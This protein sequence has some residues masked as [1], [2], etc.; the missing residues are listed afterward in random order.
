MKFQQLDAIRRQGIYFA[1]VTLAL[2][3]M[4]YFF[5]LQPP[6]TSGEEGIQSVPRS[7]L[8]GIVDF[9][10]DLAMYTFVATIFLAA[11]LLIYWIVHSPFS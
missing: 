4:V 8:L 6:F 1:M 9:K 7:R 11:L 2:S 5:C 10:N 3:Q